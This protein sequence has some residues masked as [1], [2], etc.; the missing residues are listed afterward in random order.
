MNHEVTCKHCDRYL[1]T[2]KGTTIVE[3]FPCPNSKCRAKMN[4]KIVHSGST[5]EQMNFKFTTAEVG[6]KDKI[7]VE[8]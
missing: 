6:P 7:K 2:A 8:K 5:R 3:Q 1:F 4:I